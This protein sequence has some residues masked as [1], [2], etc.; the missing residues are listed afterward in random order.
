MILNY[1]SK[2]K[3]TDSR[4]TKWNLFFNYSSIVYNVIIAIA[5]V[6]LYLKYIPSDVFGVWLATGNI[7]TWMTL[8]DPGLG[9]TMQYKIAYALGSDNKKEIGRLIG[10]SFYIS[11]LF[12]II[13]SLGALVLQ[14]N[15]SDWLNIISIQDNNFMLALALTSCSTVLMVFSFNIQGINFG[16]QSSLGVGIIF[17][18]MNIAGI[19]ATIYFLKGGFGLLAFGYAG[20]VRSL[21][22]LL[23]NFV[24][25]LIRLKL[26]NYILSSD[27]TG[28]KELIKLFSFSFIGKITGTLQ[29][30]MFEFIIAK[31]ISYG[32]VTNFKMTLSAPENSKILLIRPSVS[33][34]PIISKNFGSGDLTNIK[35]K[36]KHLLFFFIWGSVFIF[37]AFFTFNQPFVT[38]WVGE[39]FF[40]G[41]F[42]NL[43]ICTL[44]I[45][46]SFSEILAQI[47]WAIGEI[48]KNNIA[49]MIQ[50]LFFLP[51]GILASIKFGINGL[52]IAS[53][54]SYLFVTIWYFSLVVIYKLS[55]NFKSIFPLIK[56]FFFSVLIISFLIFLFKNTIY[57]NWYLFILNCFLFWISYF[58]GLFILSIKFRKLIIQQVFNRIKSIKS[59]KH[60]HI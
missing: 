8:L 18:L 23:G 57:P 59:K 15:I 43:L 55:I 2:I 5:L 42:S 48:K 56:E 33:I 39:K 12:L 21:I 3:R 6:P 45:I 51:F 50:F 24:Y 7:I 40:I 27:L 52:L 25:M 32:S 1:L 10:N 31:Y 22:Y 9:A 46:A 44:I 60:K 35:H 30:R 4:T 11:L 14:Y 16:L 34:S 41:D 47:V 37:S 49:T 19:I 53:I 38:L 58:F 28:I 54:L 36:L 13:L 17:T 26:E 29:G 20:M